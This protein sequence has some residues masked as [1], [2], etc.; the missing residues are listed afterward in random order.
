[1]TTPTDTV[2]PSRRWQLFGGLATVFVVLVGAGI[3]WAVVGSTGL[4]RVVENARY[5]RPVSRIVFDDVESGDVTIRAEGGNTGVRVQRTLH[6]TTQSPTIRENWDGDVLTISFDCPSWGFGSG[7]GV[8]Y[9]LDVPPAVQV[10]IRVSSGDVELDGLTAPARV[11]TTSGDVRVRDMHAG[12]LTAEATSG[13][14]TLDDI[15]IGTLKAETTSGDVRAVYA[16]PPTSTDI[17]VVSG[18]VTVTLPSDA[19]AYEVHLEST[20]GDLHS[21]VQSTPGA[22]AKLRLATTSGDVRV[23][24]G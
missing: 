2:R 6:W 23:R 21:D 3:A 7:C 8:D 19:T 22:T 24:R 10:E 14:I 20:S 15:S 12:T 16:T 13:D 17:S 11:H 9:T 1:M 18:D 5:D 4:N